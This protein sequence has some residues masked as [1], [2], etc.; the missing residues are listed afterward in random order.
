MRKLLIDEA[1][2]KELIAQ[3]QATGDPHLLR[4]FIGLRLEWHGYPLIHDRLV[5][6]SIFHDLQTDILTETTACRIFDYLL[7]TIGDSLSD[8]EL[9]AWIFLLNLVRE[10]R[11]IRSLEDSTSILHS[12][13]AH[14]TRI[15]D[16]KT[17][18]GNLSFWFYQLRNFLLFENVRHTRF[19][20]HTGDSVFPKGCEARILESYKGTLIFE[21][22]L[23]YHDEIFWI[24][25]GVRDAD[26]PESTPIY[27]RA[28]VKSSSGDFR[29][30]GYMAPPEFNVPS[31]AIIKRIEGAEFQIGNIYEIH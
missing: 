2:G 11:P 5:T 14:E 12:L 15:A 26:T 19:E 13:L 3:I 1:P 23:S 31:A 25:R 4:S 27:L 10:K 7:S 29:C 20:D 17:K 21:K 22:C 18:D 28:I 6:Y 24:W 9:S 8:L 30:Y 16:L